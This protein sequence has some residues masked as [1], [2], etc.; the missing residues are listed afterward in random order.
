VVQAADPGDDEAIATLVEALRRAEASEHHRE[1]LALLE[2]LVAMLPAGDGRW[3]GV[4]D[5]MPLTPEWVVDHRAD[6]AGEIGVRALRRAD[7]VL[8]RSA[9]TARQAAVKF[10]LGSLL[11]WGLCE[12]EAG[13]AL[14]E[15]AHRLFL[16]AGDSHAALLATNE[17]G[18]HFGMADVGQAHERVARDVLRAAAT[19]GDEFARLQALCSLAWALDLAGRLEEAL[20]V[21]EQGIT[22]ATAGDKVYRRSYLLGM[23]ASV[24]HLLGDGQAPE[25]LQVARDLNQ[26]FRDT[27]ILDFTAQIAWATG[28][29][30]GAAAAA[31]DQKAWDGG[32][33]VRRAFGVG[34]AVMSLS[35]MGRHAEALDLQTALDRAFRGRVCWILS[36]LA[37]WSRAVMIGLS[38]DAHQA[39]E[40]LSK[41]TEDAAASEYWCWARWMGADLAESAAYAQ[42]DTL[43]SRAH[44]LVLA[45]P[46]P[47]GGLTHDGLRSFVAGAA[48]AASGDTDAGPRALEHAAAQF[49]T[50]GWQLFEGR[51]L[52]LLG[53]S[54]IRIDRARAAAALDQAAARFQGCQAT[55]RY[56]RVLSALTGLGSRGRR[57]MVDVTGPGALSAREREVARLAAEGYA[58]REIGARLF[59]GE[60][61]VETHLANVYAKLGVASK[62]DLVR[63]ASELGI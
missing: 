17:L 54:L 41:V 23:K 13:R 33:S 44:Q 8:E 51:A 22:V 35:E 31:L 61:T 29:L 32:V 5:A 45:D 20:V 4:V 30:R 58:A 53:T 37:E 14:I 24:R 26:A 42:D 62:V 25:Q 18:Y 39:L 50:A 56:Q 11:A 59:I 60:R 48:A 40:P 52:A 43:A 55:V 57:R 47:P 46:W 9:D 7:Q 12:L 16:A 6:A 21:I 10:S 19:S 36:R 3:R 15:T 1:A 2:A 63:R 34:M 28:D 38:S 27:L 49:Q